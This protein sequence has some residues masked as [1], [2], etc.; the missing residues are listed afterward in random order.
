MNKTMAIISLFFCV[1][2]TAYGKDDAAVIQPNRFSVVTDEFDTNNNLNVS[3]KLLLAFSN[4]GQGASNQCEATDVSDTIRLFYEACNQ[5]DAQRALSYWAPEKI[6]NSLRRIVRNIEHFTINELV[7]QPC[8]GPRC[9]VWLD[10]TGW[11]RG[12]Q[13]KRWQGNITLKRYGSEWKIFS[14]NL[15][16]VPL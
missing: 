6:T 12:E 2:L 13:T 1:T 5:G 10:A 8:A 15:K 9:V 3:N 16:Q 7:A 14:W 11:S 4:G